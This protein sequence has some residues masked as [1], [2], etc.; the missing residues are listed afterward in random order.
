MIPGVVQCTSC[1][2]VHGNAA[3]S[4]RFELLFKSPWGLGLWT[5]STEPTWVKEVS[6]WSVDGNPEWV[7]EPQQ[8]ERVSCSGEQRQ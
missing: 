1:A 8:G 4:L 2:T 5:P 7:L 6:V 3:E